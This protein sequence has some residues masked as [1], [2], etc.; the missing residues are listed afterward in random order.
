MKIVLI[1]IFLL[2]STLGV[3]CQQQQSARLRRSEFPP[4][5][6]KFSLSGAPTIERAGGNS[7]VAEIDSFPSL[8]GQGVS[9]S[10]V[11]LLPCATNTPHV[12][13]RATQLFYV[14]AGSFRVAFVEE[15]GGRVVQNDVVAGDLT[16]FPQGYH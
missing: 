1:S 14:I 9:A 11:T 5:A 8:A 15:N 7:R 13:P 2:I 4:S 12:H 10:L 3:Q 16:H 6:F